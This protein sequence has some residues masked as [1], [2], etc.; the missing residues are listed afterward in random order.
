MAVALEVKG[1]TGE[2]HLGQIDRGG[3]K[4][5]ADVVSVAVHHEDE[6]AWRGAGK[7]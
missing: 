4:G 6:A 7:P 5:P 2:T 3:L 1:E